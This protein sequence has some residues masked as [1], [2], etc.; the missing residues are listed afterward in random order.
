MQLYITS[1]NPLGYLIISL[2]FD[3]KGVAKLC[4]EMGEALF[5]GFLSMGQWSKVEK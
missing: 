3:F 5:S 1:Q 2:A 4:L